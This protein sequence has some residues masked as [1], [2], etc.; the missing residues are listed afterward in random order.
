MNIDVATDQNDSQTAQILHLSWPRLKPRATKHRVKVE[1][2]QQPEKRRHTQ[3]H[4]G[5]EDFWLHLL[6]REEKPGFV[7]LFHMFCLC[8]SRHQSNFLC[9]AQEKLF[10]ICFFFNGAL[11]LDS[12]DFQESFEGHVSAKCFCVFLQSLHGK[13]NI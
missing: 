6:Q 1:H 3:N 11:H 10:W 7:C 4:P 5:P 8:V 12:W 13:M 2:P 9:F